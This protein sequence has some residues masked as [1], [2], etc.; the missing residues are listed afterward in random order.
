[1]TRTT[2]RPH[3]ATVADVMTG[4]AITVPPHAR[5]RRIVDLLGRNRISAVPVVDED[6]RPLGVVSEDDLLARERSQASLRGGAWAARWQIEGDRTRA[7]AGTAAE[8]MTAPAVT[9]TGDAPVA[10]AARRMHDNHVRRLAVVGTDG[11]LIGLVTRGDLLRVYEATDSELRTRVLSVLRPR[12]QWCDGEVDVEV[13]VGEGVA[14]LEGTVPY[15]SDA[16][17]LTALARSVDGVVDVEDALRWT[18][19]DALVGTHAAAAARP[20]T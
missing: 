2:R 3:R 19:E 10:L 1:M 5:F 18:G 8:L 12:L 15:S 6:R 17:A 11:R 4:P 7:V 20:A 14:C 16:L 13:T 9:I